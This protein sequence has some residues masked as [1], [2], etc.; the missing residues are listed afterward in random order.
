MMHRL[1]MPLLEEPSRMK[2]AWGVSV[3]RYQTMP[4]TAA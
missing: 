4:S 3:R 2:R 1:S